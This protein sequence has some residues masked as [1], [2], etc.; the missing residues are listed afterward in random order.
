MTMVE[1][2][3]ASQ[4]TTLPK[5][6]VPPANPLLARRPVSRTKST[7]SVSVSGDGSTSARVGP[8]KP[9]VPLSETARKREGNV[10]QRGLQAQERRRIRQD[11]VARGMY[12]VAIVAVH[13]STENEIGTCR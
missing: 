4:R 11:V 8:D 2:A 5:P 6:Y 1:T 3:L 13:A 7:K 10:L 12:V 9:H